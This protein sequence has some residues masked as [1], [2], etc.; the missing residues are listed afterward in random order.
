MTIPRPSH[1]LSRL[2]VIA[3]LTLSDPSSWAIE[4]DD[5]KLIRAATCEE[6]TDEYRGFVAAEKEITD[7]LKQ[8]GNTSIATN[9][10]GAT[11]LATLGIGFFTW[12][13]NSSTKEN[14]AELKAYRE[15]IAA[16][17]KKKNCT[18]LAN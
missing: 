3:A 7:D 16:E 17:A 1:T 9:V 6:L 11:A 13:D 5:M 4:P 10:L 12:N 18:L 14:L 15:A 8:S 2:L